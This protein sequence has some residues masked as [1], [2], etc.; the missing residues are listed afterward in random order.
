MIQITKAKIETIEK[1]KTTTKVYKMPIIPV[2]LSY[3]RILTTIS[4]LLYKNRKRFV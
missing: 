2:G 4:S 3:G 1:N